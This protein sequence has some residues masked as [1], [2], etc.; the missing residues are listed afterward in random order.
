MLSYTRPQPP[1]DDNRWKIVTAEMSKYGY[2]HHALIQALHAVQNA[3]GYLNREA[4]EF[5]ADS[6]RV[7]LSKVYGVASFYHYFTMTPPGKH[8][9]VV[10]TGTAC[11]IK[12]VPALLNAVKEQYGVALGETTEDGELSILS[13]RCVG[14]CGLA[15]V[16]VIDGEAV[17]KLTPE[18]LVGRLKEVVGR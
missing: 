17:G 11:Y 5:V 4:L 3:F 18:T 14:A 13:A 15:P 7:P 1:S 10:C 12:G 6:L 8:T 16:A 2:A 9:C